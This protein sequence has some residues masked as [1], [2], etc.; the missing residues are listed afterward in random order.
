MSD[1]LTADETEAA[2][3]GRALRS[4]SSSRHPTSEPWSP[5]RV[6]A[7]VA[8]INASW[9]ATD[10]EAGLAPPERLSHYYRPHNG[11]PRQ[12]TLDHPWFFETRGQE[13]WIVNAHT[14]QTAYVRPVGA[15][16]AVAR[17]VS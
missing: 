7:L 3:T 17:L 9:D 14:L 16:R 11:T 15:L 13:V 12:I 5:H 8:A 10:R 6:G 4:F 2:R 1:V